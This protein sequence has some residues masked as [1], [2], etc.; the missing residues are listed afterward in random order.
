MTLSKFFEK[1]S[2]FIFWENIFSMSGAACLAV[3][4]I[5]LN[6][7]AFL[8]G[9]ILTVFAYWSKELKERKRK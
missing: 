8:S 2:D 7:F 9:A 6:I 3:A 1:K 4:F 5:D